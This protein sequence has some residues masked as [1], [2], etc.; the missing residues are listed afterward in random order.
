MS[1]LLFARRDAA[2]AERFLAKALGGEKPSGARVINTN[3]HAGYPP[4]VVQVKD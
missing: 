2:V 4:A 1:L 3:K